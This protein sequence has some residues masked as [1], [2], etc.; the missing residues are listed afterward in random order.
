MSVVIRQ[1]IY[2]RERRGERVAILAAACAAAMLAAVM[3][4]GV[5]AGGAAAAPVTLAGYGTAAG[6]VDY[7]A[8][9]AIAPAGA[10]GAG[11]L[12]VA[13]ENNVR[14]DRFDGTGL[15]SLAWG[16]G[17]ATGAQELQTCT[18]ATGC[19]MGV[20]ETE[21]PLALRGEIGAF[22]KAAGIAVA[23]VS[24]DV[25]ISDESRVQEF[26]PSGE[27]LRALEGG[28]DEKSGG[29]GVHEKNPLAVDAAGDVWVGDYEQV[30]EFSG[31]GAH[32]AT[33]PLT[34]RGR[35]LALAVTPS[36]ED[37]YVLSS[38][39][40]FATGGVRE[41]ETATGK[42]VGAPV[43]E[44]GEPDALALDENGDLYVGGECKPNPPPASLEICTSY[45]FKQYN[46]SGTQLEQFGT[47]QV[48]GRPGYAGL[49][50]GLDGIAVDA[51]AGALYSA[52]DDSRPSESA[53]QRFP[54]PKPGPLVELERASETHSTTA[55]LEAV[56]D[57]ENHPTTYDVEYG[58][59]P[60]VYSHT[61]ATAN[62]PATGWAAE[63]V[64]ADLSGLL[65][66]TTYY[67]RISATN[68][69]HESE[70]AKT[71]TVVGEGS[72]FTTL[73]AVAIEHESALSVSSDAA[74]LGAELNP[75][76]TAA[77]W[78]VEY[79][80]AEGS[81]EH[82]TP[83]EPLAAGGS[84]E[85]VRVRLA[86]LLPSTAYR[87]RF[88]ASDEREGKPY[89]SYGAPFTFVTQPTQPQGTL[90]DGR[91][92][93]L[94]SPL[95]AFDAS[96]L[97]PRKI[98]SVIEAAAGGGAITYVATSA[99]EGSPVGEQSPNDV[100][101]ISDHGEGGWLTHDIASAHEQP[102]GVKEGHLTEFYAFSPD[103]S[104]AVVEPRG[105]ALFGGA[106]ELTPYLR[107]QTA[108]EGGVD[109]SGC[110]VPLV[111]TQDVT[112]G[113][114]WGATSSEEP[115]K[116]RYQAST[117]DLSHV[118]LESTVPLTAGAAGPG[119]YEWS[120][121]KLQLVSVLPGEGETPAAG[122]PRLSEA[123]DR[124]AIS[125]DGDRVIWEDL[126]S[127]RGL[128]MREAAGHRTIELDSPS[129]GSGKAGVGEFQDAS[130]D[131]SRVFF[132]DGQTLTAEAHDGRSLYVYEA[133]ADG[134]ANPGVLRDVTVP[135]N[136]GEPAEVM[137][138][139]PGVSEDGSVAYV[140]AGGILTA[141]PNGRGEAPVGG[142]PNLY[143]LERVE[144]EGKV[145]W[146]AM[147]VATLAAGDT[148]DWA[149]STDGKLSF[150]TA[151]VSPDGRWLAFMS[152]R[153][154][155]GYDNEDVTSEHRGERMD[156]EVFLYDG[157][158]GRLTC[159]SCDPSGARPRGV[160]Y[161]IEDG[162]L[163][164]LQENW[165]GRWVAA[166]IPSWDDM[167]LGSGIYQSRYLSDSGRLFFD[168]VDGLAPRD[169]N[170]TMDV[171]EF[172][173]PGVGSCS[174]SAQS[175]SAAQ[176]GCLGLISSGISREESVFLDASES[177][178]DVFFI[179]SGQL[180][181]QHPAGSYAVYD[182]HVCGSGWQCAAP[183]VAAPP[184]ETTSSCRGAGEA[185]PVVFGAPPSATFSGAGNRV[186]T[187]APPGIKKTPKAVLHKA[188]IR[189]EKLTRTLAHCRKRFKRAKSRA[190]R[191]SCERGAFKRYGPK[192][193]RGGR[194]MGAN[195]KRRSGR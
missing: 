99:T 67:F 103:L 104:L 33:V 96:Y 126:C 36:G 172:E 94:V 191:R 95:Q 160:H 90:P 76:G 97:P 169:V 108:C 149:G 18:S 39:G 40:N 148:N 50:G 125:T 84:P 116:A 6:Q 167:D 110:Y 131:G 20:S 13:D 48:L 132:T 59:E 75:L 63:T 124:H 143:R 70:P 58:T 4:A 105:A 100:Q 157:A 47:G 16:F 106:T 182:A 139:I 192:A 79:G 183:T 1:A 60:G 164:D 26:G 175:Y 194:A 145:E 61:I 30:Q 174:G 171:Y 170:A 43:D 179:T 24:G 142:S 44:S 128:N 122:C 93:E 28:A 23:P 184:C 66:E 17:V 120:A 117:P 11:A 80:P 136:G 181:S 127:D 38:T 190:R 27:P 77:N 37:I 146:H 112:S 151:R 9:V 193:K 134:D 177:G 168:S 62:L 188:S 129:G 156:E 101:V 140:V 45:D 74:E 15:F 185:Q 5:L 53:V 2:A 54:L 189:A 86:E 7:P 85:A 159:A 118:V 51:A 176:G 12:Y 22:G 195:A 29:K 10:P 161:E 78:W 121:G 162:R 187:N 52:S 68:H 56:L 135:L 92:W 133:N 137:G 31:T 144:V 89:V 41:Y 158:T 83:V 186:P 81:Y 119:V 57:P 165:E 102:F 180:V 150:L 14:A 163:G 71:C 69:C 109:A 113:E 123:R 114:K 8:S 73:P 25:W 166:E 138:A 155:T 154:L 72:Q 42:Q 87:Y 55:R 152:E 107:D 82:R 64:H 65:P 153:S 115:G 21:L 91:G 49:G 173:P 88:V 130:A 32:V 111:N 3:G 98:G 35:T 46:P 19:R 141:T 178:D 34:G 147:F